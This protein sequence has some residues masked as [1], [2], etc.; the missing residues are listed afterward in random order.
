MYG[1]QGQVLGLLW[2]GRPYEGTTYV[3][4]IREVFSDIKKVTGALEVR[5]AC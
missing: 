1:E 5:I 4:D 2:G 3:T